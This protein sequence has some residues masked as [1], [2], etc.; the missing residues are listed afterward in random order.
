M[1]D[2]ECVIGKSPHPATGHEQRTTS[3][4]RSGMLTVDKLNQQ[5]RRA[6]NDA[7]GGR[8]K[9]RRSQKPKAPSADR[10]PQ[11]ACAF[12]HFHTAEGARLFRPTKPIRQVS[13]C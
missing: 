3:M 4:E 5:R 12:K 2:W 13:P 11:G 7:G 6:E 1:G 9:F 8:L 10:A